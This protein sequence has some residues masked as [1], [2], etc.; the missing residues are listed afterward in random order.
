M[1]RPDATAGSVDFGILLGLA[2]QSFVDSLRAT[3]SSSGFTDLGAAYGYVFRALDDE[4]LQTAQLAQRLGMSDQG[5]AKIVTEMEAR[6]YVERS[7]DPRDGRAR[8]IRLT[9]RGKLALKTAREFHASFERDLR[10]KHGPATVDAARR[11]L[12]DVI[13]GEPGD[14]E[15]ARLRVI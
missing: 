13:G 14:I 5:A 6:G 8:R 2:Y 11:L 9:G 12:A 1:K 15:H 3:L 10:R 7:P 4:P